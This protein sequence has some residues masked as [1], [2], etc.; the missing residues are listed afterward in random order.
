MKL[1]LNKIGLDAI[2]DNPKLYGQ[3]ADL[4]GV[5]PLSLPRILNANDQRLTQA[6]ILKGIAEH[7]GVQDINELLEQVVEA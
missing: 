3:V 4:L 1:V 5:A 6:S 2:K 7:L